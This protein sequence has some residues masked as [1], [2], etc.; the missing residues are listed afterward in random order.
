[1]R[2]VPAFPRSHCPPS[3]RPASGPY[4]RQAG[5]GV[6][7]AARAMDGLA[8]AGEAVH[9]GGDQRADQ[10]AHAAGEYSRVAHTAQYPVAPPCRYPAAPSVSTAAGT[11]SCDLQ[12]QRPGGLRPAFA[13]PRD[14]RTAASPVPAPP[15]TPP[16]CAVV[17]VGT[18][19][20][21]VLT[22]R[23][24]ACARVDA[25]AGTTGRPS[26]RSTTARSRRMCSGI[27]T[28]S[29]RCR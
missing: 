24:C 27:S 25:P 9:Q 14:V 28:R 4:G 7:V 11:T 3:A 5:T 13:V 15:L 2:P 12:L 23:A 10:A 29:S 22:I 17:P 6:G 21:I 18:N 26:S 19:R 1:M 20:A 16:C 8:F